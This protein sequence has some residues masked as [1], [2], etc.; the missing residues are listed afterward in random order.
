MWLL[1]LKGQLALAPFATDESEDPGDVLDIGAGTGIWAKQFAR[2]HPNSRVVGTDLS[3]IQT[4]ENLPPNCSFVRE[5]SEEL[6][7]HDHPFDYIHWRL[8]KYY[9]NLFRYGCLIPS[10][11][12]H[13]APSTHQH[14]LTH[15]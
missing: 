5:D 14:T 8:S 7:V 1:L 3:L 11:V 2:Q 13:S 12:G 4:S 15:T 6:W 9:Y 10:S